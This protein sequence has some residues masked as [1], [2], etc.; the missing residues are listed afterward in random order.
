VRNPFDRHDTPAGIAM[1][2]IMSV[3]RPVH[4]PIADFAVGGGNL[5][6][7]AAK[8]WPT[9]RVVATDIDR[10]SIIAL[11]KR[12]TSWIVGQSNFL[13]YRSR[14]SCRALRAMPEGAGLV[15]L[16]PPFSC[17]GARKVQVSVF[18][19]KLECGTAA[20]FLLQAAACVRPD[21]QVVAVMP[22]GS[23]SSERD[24]SAW[25]LL[26][27]RFNIRCIKEFEEDAFTE[28]TVRTVIVRLC[29]L[30]GTAKRRDFD[31]GALLPPA[32]IV[33]SRLE[34]GVLRGQLQM[35]EVCRAH[36]GVPLVHSTSLQSGKIAIPLDT[37][38]NYRWTIRGPA[39]LLP[40]V[41]EPRSDKVA[42]LV[43]GIDVA[44]SDCVIA[45]ICESG[46]DAKIVQRTIRDDWKS[47]ANRYSGTC[48]K[49]IT[50]ASLAEYL[51]HVGI[52]VRDGTES[53]NWRSDRKMVL[54][55]TSIQ[56]QMV[57]R[58]GASEDGAEE[59][60]PGRAASG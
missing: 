12:E 17:P 28:V 25:S 11:K 9:L 59:S 44:I 47:I 52:R 57:K 46:G 34:V 38:S 19:E 24:K 22:A 31:A 45:L 18:G 27:E 20:A 13:V 26:G 8:R 50:L 48:A 2:M 42:I 33:A 32:S 1:A 53:K 56:N 4:G 10:R 5:L 58:A 14:A 51:E 55:A 39:V 7:A 30:S 23:V 49:F 60:A 54:A 41:G 35:H 37:V 16:N 6:R 15:L 29:G 43:D 40:R 3:L 36:R 21:G